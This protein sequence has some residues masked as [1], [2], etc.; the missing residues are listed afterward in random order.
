RAA[1][2][3]AGE[4][5]V[6]AAP[7]QSPRKVNGGLIHHWVGAT[8]LPGARLDDVL[9]V[10]RDYD[11][12]KEFYRPSVMDSQALT[13]DGAD[14]RFSMQLRNKRLFLKSA[15]D[16]DYLANNVRLDGDHYY[17]VSQTTR[18]QEIEDPGQPGQRVNPEGVGSG[19]IWK[20]F[21][22][23]RLEQADGGV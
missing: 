11:R 5:V 15:L 1:K 20:L 18:V 16:A 13:R 10:T 6:A 7:G 23:I 9:D 21:S 3:H 8:F 12:Y 14:D 4:V 17:C 19:Y 2:L 22:V